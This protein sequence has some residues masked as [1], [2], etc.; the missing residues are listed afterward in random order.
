MHYIRPFA[1][2]PSQYHSFRSS[3]MLL[4][5]DEQSVD[6]LVMQLCYFERDLK[7][8]DVSRTN[9]EALL[10]K[11]AKL[12]HQSKPQNQPQ[13]S[14]FQKKKV[15]G[16]CHYCHEFGHWIKN[17]S[18]WIADGKPKRSDQ[19]MTSGSQNISSNVVLTVCAEAVLDETRSDEWFV[20]LRSMLLISVTYL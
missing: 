1:A 7:S 19:V 3:W 9:Q 14:K 10:L 8:S 16:N 17:C 12:Q 2:L 13:K 5:D 20:E 15:R 4:S 18:K 6:E 11:S